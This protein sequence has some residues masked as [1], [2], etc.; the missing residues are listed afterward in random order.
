MYDLP[1]FKA[2]DGE[3]LA[4]MREYPFAM[5]IGSNGVP[6][7]TQLPFMVHE[8]AGKTVLY[9]H[10]MRETTH[11]QCFEQNPEAL[12]VFTGPNAYVSASWYKNPKQG[13]TW[14]YL[15]VQVRG[16]VRFMDD[17]DLPALLEQTTARFEEANSPA[18]FEQLSP[19]YVQALIPYIVGIAIEVEAVNTVFKL[20]QNKGIHDYNSIIQRLQQGDAAAQSIAA[21]MEQRKHLVFSGKQ[22]T[23]QQA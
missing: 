8:E 5:L 23:I 7:A 15:S 12:V 10:I 9:G 22:E 4:L 11:H 19:A 3:A 16:K 1:Y 21:I 20:S 6:S 18:G 2:L 13:S 17:A 14:N